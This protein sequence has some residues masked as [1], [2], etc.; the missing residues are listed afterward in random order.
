LR[1]GEAMASDALMQELAAIKTAPRRK[2]R[3]P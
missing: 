3:A 1:V 2:A